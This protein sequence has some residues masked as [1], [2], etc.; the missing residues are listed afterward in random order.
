MPRESEEQVERTRRVQAE[1]RKKIAERRGG[2]VEQRPSTTIRERIP[3]LVRPAQTPPLD[4][5]GGPMRRIIREL[6]E[7]AEKRLESQPDPEEAARAAAVERQQRLASE[8]RVLEAQRLAEQKR[9]QGIA[10]MTKRTQSDSV[11]L[12]SLPADD[13]RSGLRDPRE[14]RRAIVLREILGAPVAFR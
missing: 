4:P 11:R 2:G 9:A 13:I 7:A 5:F 12:G 6:E 3:P 1:I 14:L 10:A 8:M